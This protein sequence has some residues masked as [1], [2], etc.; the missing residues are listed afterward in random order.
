MVVTRPTT[1][2]RDPDRPEQVVME[3][4]FNTRLPVVAAEPPWVTVAPPG[5]GRGLVAG[6]DVEVLT[7]DTSPPTGEDVV[8]GAELFTGV[9]YLWAGTSAAGWDCSGFTSSVYAAHGVVIPRDA[10]D[11]AGEGTP[12]AK[13]DLRPGD[14]LF[15]ATGPDR[16]TVHHVA[17]YVGGG[18]MI[19][20]PATGRKVET[21][22]VDQPG[23]DD[24]FWGA[25][26]YLRTG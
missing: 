4:S 22:A 2:L 20:A 5:G 18:R 24:E 16:S 15:F 3:L 14:L 9:E 25:R 19:Q 13:A 17:M 26:R 1:G 11:Q 12:V 7:A 21:V 10:D 6:A 8:R 23:L